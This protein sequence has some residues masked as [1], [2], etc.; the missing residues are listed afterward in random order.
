MREL[1][2]QK[3]LHHTAEKDEFPPGKRVHL[4]SAGINFAA[5]FSTFLYEKTT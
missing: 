2:P 4:F 5:N 3:A 1:A